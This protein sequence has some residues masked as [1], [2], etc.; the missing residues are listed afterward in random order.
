MTDTPVPV[1]Y[2]LAAA[3]T[4]D[5]N[6]IREVFLRKIDGVDLVIGVAAAH[7]GGRLHLQAMPAD[8]GMP[9]VTADLTPLLRAMAR[10]ARAGR[11]AAAVDGGSA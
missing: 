7:A 9:A 2:T 4:D 11:K 1:P 5:E 6:T 8:D 10:A 3:E